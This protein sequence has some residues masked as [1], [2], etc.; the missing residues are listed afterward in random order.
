MALERVTQ[1]YELPGGA[2]G[3]IWRGSPQRG[4]KARVRAVVVFRDLTL[5]NDPDGGF[6][7]WAE[8]E[9]W[10]RAQVEEVTA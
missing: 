8:A 5:L 4:K 10:M 3:T 9:A 1:D 2:R 6:A 7:T